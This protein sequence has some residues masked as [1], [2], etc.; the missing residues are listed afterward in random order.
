M[1]NDISPRQLF[2][3][4]FL[5]SLFSSSWFFSI[6][7][8]AFYFHTILS[9]LSLFRFLFLPLSLPICPDQMLH[10]RTWI[11]SQFHDVST[12]GCLWSQA[13][14]LSLSESR[15]RKTKLLCYTCITGANACL[16]SASVAHGRGETER[17]WGSNQGAK[18]SLKIWDS[19]PSFS[20]FQSN[21]WVSW[22]SNYFM[23]V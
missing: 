9:S 11:P 14:S 8:L 3:V 13:F 15:R 4:V 17:R 6:I 18:N 23:S 7:F 19:M 16:K 20:D 2:H 5:F 21:Y 10:L 12:W 22:L 1:T